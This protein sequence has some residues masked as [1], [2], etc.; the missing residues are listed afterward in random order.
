MLVSGG[1]ESG[2]LRDQRQAL[3]TDSRLKAIEFPA[4]LARFAD[5]WL[6]EVADRAAPPQVHD[7]CLIAVGGY[8]RSEL[9]P[10]SDLDLL[11]VHRDVQ[12]IATL[13]DSL[14][15]PIWDEGIKLD[16]SVRT[17]D[18]VLAAA[19]DD[20]R[21]ALGLLEARPIW[22]TKGLGDDVIEE[23]RRQWRR[24]SAVS[25]IAS[26]GE[27]MRERRDLHGDVAFLLE[28][29]LK[30]SH[31]GLR[32]VGVLRAWAT[33][34]D[35]LGT[36]I[37]LNSVESAASVL[38]TTRVAL[39]R[40]SGRSGDRL[41]LQDQDQIAYDLG[42]IDADALMKE[43]SSSGREIAWAIDDAWRRR[44]LWSSEIKRST[45]L[46]R[47]GSRRPKTK[48]AMTDERILVGEEVAFAVNADPA[49]PSTALLLAAVAAEQ[50]IPIARDALQLMASSM[51]SPGD[52]WGAATRHNLIR[53]LSAGP[54][55]LDA[56][57]A[58]DHEGL[59][60]RLLPEWSQVRNRPQRNAYHRYTVDRH[61]L[62]AAVIASRHSAEL[63]RPDLLVIGTFLHD[64]GK[65]F[66]GD[67]T[68]I[69]VVKVADIAKRMGFDGADVDTLVN[70]CRCHLLL[71]DTATRRDIDDP[72]TVSMVAA[73][74]GDATTLDLLAALT[75][76]D[77]LATGPAA[78]GSWKAGLVARL[79]EQVARQLAGLAPLQKSGEVVNVH[80]ALVEQVRATGLPGARIDPP[81]IVVAALDRRGLLAA[82]TGV[83]ALLGVDVHSA[84][85]AGS[86][87]VAIEVFTVEP[88]F[89]FWPEES[90]VVESVKEALSGSLDIEA[91]LAER[92]ATYRM[93]KVASAH[94]I[95]PR[96]AFDNAASTTSTVIELRAVDTPGLLHRV[97]QVL[98]E[99]RLDIVSARASTIGSEAID[100]FYVKNAGGEKVL[101]VEEQDRVSAALLAVITP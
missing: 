54:G 69:G 89:G 9:C 3:I 64:I 93:H 38:L 57:E 101:D 79:V 95:S 12:G 99:A 58:L 48:T 7:I 2:S 66:P 23:A 42:Y 50:S 88:T 92:A 65:G 36:Y 24:S 32:D 83:F 63:A 60:V 98:Y 61:L 51:A 19:R 44:S 30:E 77:S 25:F 81:M 43:V 76:A 8:G 75:R 82:V 59:I 31:G 37:D 85:A 71:A 5:D 47:F 13:A 67:H 41:V 53:L 39:Q 87:G 68:E 90:R 96:V 14:W 15:Y 78:W 72:A 62:E 34:R 45:S 70:L 1:V 73:Q 6:C 86:E 91:G 21:V 55:A 52:P 97:T 28:P 35:A 11:L 17:P 10:A 29:D 33:W 27:Q 49:N 4:L 20:L 84:D 22:G 74:V 26:I 100:A 94:P 16:H 18:E 80:R 40:R 56:F 46:R